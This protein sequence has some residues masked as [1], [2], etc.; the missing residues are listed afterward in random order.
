M[1]HH[2]I[3][4]SILLVALTLYALGFLGLSSAALIT[5]AAF[6]LWFWVRLIARRAPVSE[7]CAPHN[8]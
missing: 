4:V 3:T 6:E 8:K 1:K 7:S 5:G 2:L